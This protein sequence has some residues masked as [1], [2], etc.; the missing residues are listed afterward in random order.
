MEDI[1]IAYEEYKCRTPIKFGGHVEDRAT[2]MNVDY[3][4]KT[5]GVRAARGFGSMP[6]GNIW[7]FPSI[8]M[9]YET[10][11]GAIVPEFF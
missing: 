11:L 2:V 10:T 7:S 9:S 5:A 4:V 8:T 6:L 3:S 1:S